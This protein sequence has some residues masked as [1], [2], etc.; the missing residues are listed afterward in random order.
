MWPDRLVVVISFC[1]SKL[2]HCCVGLSVGNAA[3]KKPF[4]IVFNRSSYAAGVDFWISVSSWSVG[5]PRCHQ[6][7]DVVVVVVLT[8]T[9]SLECCF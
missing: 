7:I 5:G 8:I 3:Y 9:Q 1:I 2:S 6:L 4:N